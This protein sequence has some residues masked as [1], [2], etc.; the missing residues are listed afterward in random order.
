MEIVF[1][2]FFSLQKR[3]NTAKLCTIMQKHYAE[4]YTEALRNYAPLSWLK[5]WMPYRF[6]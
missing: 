2:V 4:T 6:D 1:S 3:E 5:I